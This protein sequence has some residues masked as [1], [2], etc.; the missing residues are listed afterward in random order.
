MGFLNYDHY[1]V[2][3]RIKAPIN[4]RNLDLVKLNH[5]LSDLGDKITIDFQ[6]AD[7]SEL[8]V[9]KFFTAITSGLYECCKNSKY[10]RVTSNR[11]PKQKNCTSKHFK[12]ISDANYKSYI[13][14]LNDVDPCQA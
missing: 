9:T 2:N 12:A 4:V 7:S 10:H 1:D 8:S 11:V 6:D 3:K 14:N 13:S 5:K